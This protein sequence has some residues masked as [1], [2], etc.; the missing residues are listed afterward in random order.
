MFT[1][2]ILF[3]SLQVHK[4]STFLAFII[5]GVV[6]LAS[7]KVLYFAPD[8]WAGFLID[9]LDKIINYFDKLV[10]YEPKQVPESVIQAPK[11]ASNFAKIFDF[12]KKAFVWVT[13]GGVFAYSGLFVLG[14][15]FGLNK[16]ILVS[17]LP[18]APLI[19]ADKAIQVVLISNN[20]L[21]YDWW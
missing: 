14:L 13:V 2:C 6:I 21:W 17:V 19:V 8:T 5:G 9:I 7:A 18:Y 3:L 11:G 15:S 16:L 10:G 4:N 1:N 20:C 12:S